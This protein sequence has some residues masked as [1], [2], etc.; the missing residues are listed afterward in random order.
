MNDKHRYDN[1]LEIERPK[2]LK[3]MS[4]WSRAA[5]FSAFAALVGYDDRIEEVARLTE[6]AVDLTE[7]EVAGLDRKVQY[8]RDHINEHPQVNI[9]YYIPDME[10]HRASI[11]TG[12]SYENVK[13]YVKKVDM[14]GKMLIMSDGTGICFN[15]IISLEIPG[16]EERI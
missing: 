10:S 3:P 1:M 13:D 2:T 9:T 8:I 12:G 5:Q 7:E 11:K 15:R 6:D 4:D 16:N 14:Y